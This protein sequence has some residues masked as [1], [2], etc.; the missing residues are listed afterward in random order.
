M[1]LTWFWSYYMGWDMSLWS[2]F[3]NKGRMGI[4]LSTNG[5]L[6]YSEV[7]LSQLLSSILGKE[8]RD[9]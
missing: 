8:S 6:Y 2:D 3:S 9:K 1:E 7:L 4:C 5:L